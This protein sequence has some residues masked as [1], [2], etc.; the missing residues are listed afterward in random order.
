MEDDT[1]AAII[2]TLH[3]AFVLHNGRN[4]CIGSDKLFQLPRCSYIITFNT[5]S[6]LQDPG[7]GLIVSGVVL[8]SA[9]K[10]IVS[11][12]ESCSSND[13]KA[14]LDSFNAEH[15]DSIRLLLNN[16][17]ET[18]WSPPARTSVKKPRTH[19]HLQWPSITY[20]NQL[21]YT[22]SADAAGFCF[23]APQSV[24]A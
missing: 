15:P 24:I 12:S 4:F 11:T 6:W 8:V 2:Q 7:I 14:A 21:E 10:G 16:K 20:H 18:V 23:E 17:A 1:E 3:D 22:F 5:S 13:V 9:S 19:S